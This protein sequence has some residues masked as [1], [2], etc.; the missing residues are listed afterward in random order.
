MARYSKNIPFITRYQWV[1]NLIGVGVVFLLL[2]LSIQ[3][4]KDSSVNELV[5]DIEPVSENK[6]LISKKEIEKVIKTEIGYDASRGTMKRIDLG[7]LESLIDGDPRVKE[8]EVYIDKHLKIH[9]GITQREPIVRI[10]GEK[11]SYYLDIDGNYIPLSKSAA[12][13][14][15]VVTGRVD[16][17]HPAFANDKKSNINAVHKLGVTIYEDDFLRALVEQIEFDEND[18]ITIIPK[19]GRNKIKLGSI[20]NLD[21]KFYRLKVFYEKAISKYGI[22][23]FSELDLQYEDRVFGKPLKS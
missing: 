21:D 19:M 8:S 18:Q 16:A 3:M 9:V 13:R 12:I 23:K 22:D 10:H 1:F 17:Y 14:V 20:E 11:V 5:V 6:Y 4:I 7:K 2:T 15:P